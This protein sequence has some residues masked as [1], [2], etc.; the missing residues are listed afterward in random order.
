MTEIAIPFTGTATVHVL[1]E[2][3]AGLAGDG[4]FSHHHPDHSVSAAAFRSARIH[5]HWTV[6]SG[7]R[8]EGRDIPGHG[9][10]FRSGEHA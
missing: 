6:C 5:D 10:P 9:G 3:Y 7:D 1:R 2:G 4:V 8:C